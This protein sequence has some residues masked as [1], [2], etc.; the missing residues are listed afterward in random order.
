MLES[1][2]R[3]AGIAEN[4]PVPGT[5]L[6]VPKAVAALEYKSGYGHHPQLRI[7]SAAANIRFKFFIS[8]FERTHVP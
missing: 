1:H 8:S 5:G 3:K 6:L 2:R 7:H 4:D